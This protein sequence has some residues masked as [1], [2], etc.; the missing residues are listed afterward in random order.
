MM[1]QRALAVLLLMFT[2]STGFAQK[3]MYLQEIKK[4]VEAGW[5]ANPR[6]IAEWRA[7]DKSFIL[8]GYNA[9][10]HPVYLASTMAFLYE[11]TGERTYA[12]RA[13]SLLV[14]FGDL[15]SM[16]PKDYA[17]TRAEYSDGVPA[18][19]NFFFLPPYSR[20]YMRIR[21]SGVMDAAA[22]A[23]IE[24]DIA[25]SINFIFRFPEWGA[26]NRAMLRAEALIYACLAMP[27]HPDAGKW[28]QMAEAIAFDNLNHWEVEDASNYNPI[29]LHAV[30]SY[31]DAAGRPDVFTSPMMRYYMEYYARQIAP[32]GTIPDYG[33]AAWNSASSGLRMVAFFEKGAAVSHNPLYKWAA[34][35]VLQTVKARTETL[36][37]G[38]AYHLA[39]AFRWADES[40]EAATPTSLSQEVLDEIIGKKV[41]FR[42]GWEPTSTYLLLD[43]KD[44]GDGGWLDREYLRKTISVEEE[45]MHHGHADE[46]SI[47]LL[48]EGGSVLLTDA[49]YRDGLPSGKY[50]AWRADY[51][52]NRLV[53]RKNKRDTSQSVLD[54]VR[55]SGAYRKVQTHKVDFLSLKDVDMSRTRVVDENLGY[56][57]DRVVVYVRRPGVFVVIDGVKV[58]RPDYFTFTNFWHTQRVLNRGDHY[59]DVVNDSIRSFT[60]P[61]GRS[62]LIAFPETYGKAE[63]MEPIS[64]QS[65]QELAI[66]QT[67]SSQYKAGDMEAFVTVLVPH[68]RD[69]DPRAL[70]SQFKVLKTSAPYRS[71]AVEMTEGGRQSLIMVKLDLDMEVARENLRPRYLYELGK[72]ACGDFETDAH[73]LYAV[74]DG[75]S[76]SYSASVFLKVAYRGKTL[77]EALPNTHPLQL[78]GADPRVGY[79]KWRKWED[80][81]HNVKP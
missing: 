58:L 79:S 80:T 31:A 18:L 10:A 19:S 3:A 40:V 36:G 54:F 69:A 20:A 2:V 7:T 64:R 68:G 16:L 51:F 52:H 42:N 38:D 25:E 65:Q 4:A 70:A 78:D 15:R 34:R 26:H 50:G 72:V 8:W 48:M 41:V 6:I 35:S 11:Q 73:F 39:D 32:S 60:F 77:V 37:V 55:N 45:K 61:T 22:K 29:W 53:T 63:G 75:A 24:K 30:L 14:G 5:Q 9:P 49:G 12:E 47:V 21:N 43:Y 27:Q 81:L 1:T 13:A 74:K 46:N 66:Y 44:E 23:K 71:I 28:K 76:L 59:Y 33:D 57:W 56:Q 62:L 67:Q 17:K